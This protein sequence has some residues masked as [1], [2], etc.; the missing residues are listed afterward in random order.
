MQTQVGNGMTMTVFVTMWP[1]LWLFDL[2]VNACQ[3]TAI[4]YTCTKFGVDSSS[5]FPFRVQTNIQ[6][7]A[8]ECPTHAVGYA[9]VGKFD[10]GYVTVV[11][12]DSKKSEDGPLVYFGLPST[13][14]QQQQMMLQAGA[15]GTKKPTQMSAGSLTLNADDTLQIAT[16]VCSTKLTHNGRCLN[17]VR[18]VTRP[19]NICHFRVG[20]FF[21]LLLFPLLEF[22]FVER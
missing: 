3:V 20:L 10:P 22:W 8:T 12:I 16:L 6:T 4:E 17:T 1:D 21:H 11:K 14:Q 18:W 5:R 19:V 13:A 15:A 2:W 9:G 7:D